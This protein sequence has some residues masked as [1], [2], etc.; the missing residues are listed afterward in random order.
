MT[1]A[2]KHLS[3]FLLTTLLI[4]EL[5]N[6]SEARIITVAGDSHHYVDSNFEECLNIEGFDRRKAKQRSVL[7]NLMF[8]YELADRFENT[9]ITSN[10][11]H[12]GAVATRLGMNNGIYSWLR[13]IGSHTL[14]RN[15]I[16]S[17]KGADTIVYLALSPELK[18]ITG[19]YFYER[20]IIESS[21]ESKNIEARKRLW[22]M[23]LKMTGLNKEELGDNWKY[24]M[25]RS[26]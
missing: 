10:A 2:T 19:K 12:P 7:A 9:N 26:I 18:G 25:P 17:Q 20:K 5:K 24:F 4:D 14:K 16:S 21:I 3:H 22:D 23:S 13:H 1:F 6:S 15:L 8:T 11:V